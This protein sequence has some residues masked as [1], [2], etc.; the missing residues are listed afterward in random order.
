MVTI[1]TVFLGGMIFWGG[2]NWSME[3]TNT[4]AF[5]ISCHAMETFMLKEYK[6]TSH[7]ANN[8]G[9]RASCRDCHVPKEWVHKVVRK[10]HATNELF[11]WLKGSINTRE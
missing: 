2:F 7:Y 4:E 9:V 6:Q 1:A 8:T 3:L 5:C 10:V 11:H